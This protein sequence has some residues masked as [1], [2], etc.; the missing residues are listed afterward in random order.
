MKLYVLQAEACSN[1]RARVLS[2][3]TV[4]QDLKRL[5]AEL[6]A[7]VPGL[8]FWASCIDRSPFSPELESEVFTLPLRCAP[9]I[10]REVQSA[11]RQLSHLQN[12][13]DSSVPAPGDGMKVRRLRHHGNGHCAGS[14]VECFQCGQE[15]AKEL[16]NL[17]VGAKEGR[18]IVMMLLTMVMTTI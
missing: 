5:I 1:S 11:F 4:R 14:P 8:Y 3:S 16:R 6:T 10:V 18:L 2:I 13:V 12:Y 9:V 15:V 17:G 7:R